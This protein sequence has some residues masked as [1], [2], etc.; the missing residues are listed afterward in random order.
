MLFSINVV[1]SHAQAIS[2]PQADR[3]ADGPLDPP[4]TPLFLEKYVL[5]PH[6]PPLFLE[7]YTL[8]P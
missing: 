5:C 6:R 8:W 2:H 7:K 1:I 3:A 4:W